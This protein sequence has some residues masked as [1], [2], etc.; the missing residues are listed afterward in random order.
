MKNTKEQL[1]HKLWKEFS[2]KIIENWEEKYQKKHGNFLGFQAIANTFNFSREVKKNIDKD[3]EKQNIP[4]EIKRVSE[5]TLNNLFQRNGFTGNE[6]SSSLDM[7]CVW[8]GYQDWDDYYS[9][10]EDEIT[11]S[12]EISELSTTSIR[13]SNQVFYSKKIRFILLALFVLSTLGFWFWSKKEEKRDQE[14]IKN[15]I[16]KANTAEFG[17][18]AAVPMIDTTVLNEFYFKESVSLKTVFGNAIRRGNAGTK[19]RKNASGCSIEELNIEELNNNSAKVK[20]KE[21]W[22]LVWYSVETNRDTIKFEEFNNQEYFLSK[23]D[24][25][26]KIRLNEYDGEAQLIRPSFQ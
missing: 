8:L 1:I 5:G 26:W 13:T 16:I 19:L 6:K 23:I 9:K 22:R 3:L 7:Y 10:H 4:E 24:G 11:N 21:K 12:V 15:V 17:V 18:Y 2:G 14:S 25:V 20:T